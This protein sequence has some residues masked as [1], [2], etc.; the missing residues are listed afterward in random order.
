VALRGAGLAAACLCLALVTGC[1]ASG[2]KGKDGDAAAQAE[3]TVDPCKP[4]CCCRVK[5]NYYV[6]YRCA[7][8]TECAADGGECATDK[9]SKCRGTGDPAT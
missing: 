4:A 3:P 8:Q 7:L 9:W 1:S 2:A 6:R 5:E